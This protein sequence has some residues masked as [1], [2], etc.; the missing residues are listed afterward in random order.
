ML[1]YSGKDDL[2]DPAKWPVADGGGQQVECDPVLGCQPIS[3]VL[4]KK[5]IQPA[6]EVEAKYGLTDDPYSRS[7]GAWE[8]SDGR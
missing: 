7:L 8:E 3:S 4:F 1:I 5:M 2:Y 6:A